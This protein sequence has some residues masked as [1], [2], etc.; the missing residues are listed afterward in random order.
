[1]AFVVFDLA[2][3][4]G[5]GRGPPSDSC[6]DASLGHAADD[7]DTDNDAAVRATAEA[8]AAQQRIIAADGPAEIYLLSIDSLRSS[9]RKLEHE[10][11]ELM[12]ARET[13]FV[14]FALQGRG[15][16][17][18]VPVPRRWP[19]YWTECKSSTSA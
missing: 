10:L 17:G 15:T 13:E 7:D 4:L 8:I 11:A 18:T 12:S 16:T 9:Q 5:G 14:D 6:F 1:M 2:D 3:G 19:S